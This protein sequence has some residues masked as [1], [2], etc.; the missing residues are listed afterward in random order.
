MP[1]EKIKAN[2]DTRLRVKP[3]AQEANKVIIRVMTTAVP[4]II[5]SRQ[6]RARSTS[7]TTKA[8]ANASLPISFCAFSSAVWP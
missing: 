2:R 5:A 1:M 8:V 4:T 7:N 6:P 3:Q